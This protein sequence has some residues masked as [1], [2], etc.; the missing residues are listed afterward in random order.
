MPSRNGIVATITAWSRLLAIMVL[1]RSQRSTN[2][3]AMSPTIRLGTA[4]AMRVTPTRNAD[5]VWS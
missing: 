2:T 5:P 4:V 1:R 3:P